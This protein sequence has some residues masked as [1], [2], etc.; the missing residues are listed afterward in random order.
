M[1]TFFAF[2]RS[3]FSSFSTDS[4]RLSRLHATYTELGEASFFGMKRLEE[5]EG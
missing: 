5:E 3:L 4:K 2:L 1:V